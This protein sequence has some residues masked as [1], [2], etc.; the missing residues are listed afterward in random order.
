MNG[1]Q[2]LLAS[3]P[4]NAIPRFLMLVWT[5]AISLRAI[6]TFSWFLSPISAASWFLSA[7]YA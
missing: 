6:H 7:V 1:E 5:I 2:E 4:I 3:L